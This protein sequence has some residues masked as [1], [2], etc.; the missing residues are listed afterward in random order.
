MAVACLDVPRLVCFVSRGGSRNGEVKAV[1]RAGGF[2]QNGPEAS[3]LDGWVVVSRVR[4]V[5]VIVDC[6]WCMEGGRL[7]RSGVQDSVDMFG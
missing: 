6:F 4:R 7:F 3:Q 5:T 1:L 2:L